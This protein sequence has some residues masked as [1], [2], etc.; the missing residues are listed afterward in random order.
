MS[1]LTEREFAE[2]KDS[3]LELFRGRKTI[4]K[5][6]LWEKYKHHQN[7][8]F[9]TENHVSD[10]LSDGLLSR[11]GNEGDK[12][13]S[14]KLSDK[15]IAVIRNMKLYGCLTKYDK[16]ESERN[17]KPWQKPDWWK[18]Q[19]LK[20]GITTILGTALGIIIGAKSCRKESQPPQTQKIEQT[21]INKK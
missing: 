12:D 20:W 17:K 21:S 9:E 7:Y 3:I 10:L 8:Y 15:G 14:F 16:A 1:D 2:F 18:E 11:V 13:E 4:L 6:D 5:T 19:V